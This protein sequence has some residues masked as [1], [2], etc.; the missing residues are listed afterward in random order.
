MKKFIVTVNGSKYEVDVEEVKDGVAASS[1]VMQA[2]TSEQVKVAAP[3]KPAVKADTAVPTGAQIIKSPMPGT[4]LKINV[5]S[6][7]AVKKGQ[8]LLILEAMKMENEISAPCDGIV[9]SINVS[10]GVS[11]NT[12]DVLVSLK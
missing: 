3:Q 1:P 8:T 11:V 10:Q 5:R 2:T 4:I 6:G 9:A 7:D 12:G